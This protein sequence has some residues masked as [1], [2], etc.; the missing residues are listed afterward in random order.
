MWHWGWEEAEGGFLG[1]VS[2]ALNLHAGLILS[3][4]GLLYFLG[5]HIVSRYLILRCLVKPVTNALC[6]N[7][8]LSEVIFKSHEYQGL[9]TPDLVATVPTRWHE[10]LAFGICTFCFGNV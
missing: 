6:F 10:Q 8:Q 2:G 4:T 7:G 5:R 1:A 3:L 9:C